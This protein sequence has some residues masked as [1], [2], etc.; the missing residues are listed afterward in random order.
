MIQLI[1]PRVV[2]PLSECSSHVRLQGLVPDTT[3]TVVA[4]GHTV[5]QDRA[6]QSDQTFQ[7]AGQLIAGQIVRAKQDFSTEGSDFTPDGVTVL[8]GPANSSELSP[9]DLAGHLYACAG[10]LWLDGAFPGATVDVRVGTPDQQSVTSVD[11]NAYVSLSSP[12]GSG[13][14]IS[15]RQSACGFVG[16][17]TQLPAPDPPPVDNQRRLL[18]PKVGEPLFECQQQLTVEKVLE[19][20]TVT[21]HREG[22]DEFACVSSASARLNLVHPLH[23]GEKI[24]ASQAFPGCEYT[25]ER[26]H[27]PVEVGPADLPAPFLHGPICNR[28]HTVR[29]LGLEPGAQVMFMSG[30]NEFAYG[31][32]WDSVC[33]FQMPDLFGV[34]T[35]SVKQGLC[36][37]VQ[38]S[39]TSNEVKIDAQPTL[40]DLFLK[41]TGPVYECGRLVH[42]SGC[43]PGITV[44]LISKSRGGPMGW[45]YATDYEVD[46]AVPPLQAGDLVHA[47]ASLCGS[48]YTSPE[49]E[50][51]TLS[52]D[53]APPRV[54]DPVED[55]GGAVRVCD[56][57]PG[58]RVEVYVN[59]VFAGMAPSS[60]SEASVPLAKPLTDGD[61]VS[62]RQSL[63]GR[64]TSLGEKVTYREDLDLDFAPWASG[65]ISERVC[66]LT[67]KRDPEPG[68]AHLN[69]TTQWGVY[70]TDLG[71]N[72][73]HAGRHYIFFGDE[74]ID[75][76]PG[77][78]RDAEP[79]FY[80]TDLSPEPSGFHM[81]PIL[82]TG[83]NKFRRLAVNGL[84]DLGNFEVPTGG[85]SYN[86][87]LFLFVALRNPAPMQ[88]SFLVSG[89]DPHNPFDS[90]FQVD[91]DSVG[92][93]DDPN[94]TNPNPSRFINISPWVVRNGDWPDLQAPTGDGLLLYGSGWY[95]RSGVCLAWA[96]LTPGSD[97]PP[98]DQW[99]FF[100]AV[101]KTWSDPGDM[102]FAQPFPGP[103]LAGELSVSWVPALHRWVMLTE[104]GIV[105]GHVARRP[106]GPWFPLPQEVFESRRDGA[107]TKYVHVPG[108]DSLADRAAF[109]N[110]QGGA[111]GPYLVPRFTRW[112]PWTRTATL[113]YVMSTH[114]PYQVMLMKFRLRCGA[115]CR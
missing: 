105:R 73:H 35:L 111:Y 71:I 17:V 39:D 83:S 80:T 5:V 12:V 32:A 89:T 104:Q 24:A 93:T 60:L 54:L 22:G 61:S 34:A 8:R 50:V 62:A 94:A 68:H 75:E 20:A 87:K 25:S 41:V 46:V 114:V 30:P 81:Q 107:L 38:W 40:G 27:P 90:L 45:A 85:F 44:Y 31:T 43:A 13:E 96:P 23:L 76:S 115:D 52:H 67:G 58:A 88:R 11:G 77:E 72:F 36:S 26:S 19:G 42:V 98:P 112:N 78:L 48:P 92:G 21:V 100:D 103:G 4:D 14:T 56:V 57:V 70:G 65:H 33:D 108:Q 2:L 97:P 64:T 37:P 99:R 86:N 55:C 53:L 18:P 95:R 3:V 113:Y 69:D 102:S 47:A 1:P 74:G 84:A 91:S 28:D 110:Q 10:C 66:Q 49:Q 109:A 51:Q 15:V 9:V 101:A 63:C 59:G 16:P 82:Q 29:V 106:T 6:S 7:V 79:V